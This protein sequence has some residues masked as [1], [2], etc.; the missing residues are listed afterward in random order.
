MVSGVMV[1]IGNHQISFKV[2]ELTLISTYDQTD[3]VTVPIGFYLSILR[4]V[5]A[6]LNLMSIFWSSRQRRRG[7]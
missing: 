2:A 6:V 4:M 5:E 3:S 1:L 7:Q